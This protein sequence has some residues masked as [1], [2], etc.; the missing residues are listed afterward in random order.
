[1]AARTTLRKLRTQKLGVGVGLAIGVVLTLAVAA[2]VVLLS[3]GNEEKTTKPARPAPRG[4]VIYTLRWGD[5]V[6]DPRTGTRCQATGEGGIPNLYCTH[7]ARGRY[8]AVFWN[9]E[10][11]VYGPGS[12]PFDPTYSF[13]WWRQLR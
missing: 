4:H 10:L 9:D 1:M 2:T 13:K 11:Q 6:R 5:V 12:E 8:E 3:A 7:T